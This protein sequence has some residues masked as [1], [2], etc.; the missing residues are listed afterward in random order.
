MELYLKRT[1]A[2]QRSKKI[3][4]LFTSLSRFV[5]REILALGHENG[6]LYKGMYPPIYPNLA[7]VANTI[8]AY[9]CMIQIK[10]NITIH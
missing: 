7:S 6:Q 9:L 2:L 10:Q 3:K 5:D 1:I 8:A 4:T